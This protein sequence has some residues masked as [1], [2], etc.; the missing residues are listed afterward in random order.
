MGY[1]CC[2]NAASVLYYIVIR[3]NLQADDPDTGGG[4]LSGF[5]GKNRKRSIWTCNKSPFGVYY[6]LT[7]GIIQIL[8]GLIK[9]EKTTLYTDRTSCKQNLSNMY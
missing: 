7:N 8:T 2:Q 9:N 3:N 1:L 6:I 5:A 4:I